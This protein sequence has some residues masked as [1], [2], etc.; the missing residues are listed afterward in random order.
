VSNVVPDRYR[1]VSLA[2]I[3][4]PLTRESVVEFLTGREVYRRTRYVVIRTRDGT[5]GQT[6]LASVSKA[7]EEPLF[8]PVTAVD[9]LAMPDD[10]AWVDAPEVDTGVPSQLARVAREHAPGTRCV[11]VH[12]RHSHVSF[13]LD[14]DPI[15]V[16]VV[17]VAPPYPAK[18]LDQAQALLDTADDLPPV[19]L[20]PDITDLTALA[21]SH[22]AAGY[23]LP[24][25]GSGIEIPG[26]RVDFLDERPPEQDW[27]LV[28]CARSREI[29]RWCYGREAPYAESCPRR[30]AGE[31]PVARATLTKCCL[32][33][34]EA[35][36]FDGTGAVVPWGAS[37]SLIRAALTEV[38][39]AAREGPEWSPG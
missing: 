14:P 35:F 29:H 21:A 11:V 39:A 3:S 12:G 28:G 30:L 6:A 34:E 37:L 5:G 7:S 27:L 9:V 31:G 2:S 25:R 38:V 17:D 22:P 32:L 4:G 13:I 8:S 18:L 20:V 1:E 26:A 23:L 33:E 19:E 36:D 16:R 15:R 24:C 10:A